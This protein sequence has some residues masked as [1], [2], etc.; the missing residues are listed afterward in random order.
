MNIIPTDHAEV[1]LPNRTETTIDGRAYAVSLLAITADRGGEHA[2]KVAAYLMQR[3]LDETLRNAW[4]SGEGD[5][6]N[7]HEEV[8]RRLARIIADP[9]GRGVAADPVTRIACDLARKAIRAAIG[10]KAAEYV[11]LTTEE[12]VVAFLADRKVAKGMDRDAAVTAAEETYAAWR[13]KAE[14]MV[15][16]AQGATVDLDI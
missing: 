10:G 1:I 16:V 2:S 3:G 12:K 4:T 13:A 11:G 8:A 6:K 15:V 7:S 14:E 9:T 5:K